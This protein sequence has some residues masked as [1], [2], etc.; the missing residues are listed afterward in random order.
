MRLEMARA[1][2]LVFQR[3]SGPVDLTDYRLWWKFR[4]GANWRCPSGEGDTAAAIED[5]PV[6]HVAYQDAVAYADWAGKS[7]PTEAEWEYAARGG[8]EDAEFAW[9]DELAPGGKILANYWQGE[10]PWA[11]RSAGG[12]ECTSPVRTFLPNGYGL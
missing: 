10:F 7:L 4:F 6:V 2:S 8:L 1:G 12:W 3:T 5:H 9:G 11:N